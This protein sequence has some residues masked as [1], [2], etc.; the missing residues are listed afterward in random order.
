VIVNLRVPYG[1]SK[2][3]LWAQRR[4]LEARRRSAVDKLQ[5]ATDTPLGSL[6]QAG[7]TALDEAVRLHLDP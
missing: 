5:L 7:M 4:R 3:E 6:P 2:S 1:V